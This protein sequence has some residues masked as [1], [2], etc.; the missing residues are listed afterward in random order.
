MRLDGLLGGNQTWSVNPKFTYPPT[1]V[2]TQ[3]SMDAWAAT[4]TS[5]GFGPLIPIADIVSSAVAVTGV[6]C[7]YINELGQSVV[8]SKAVLAA[9][10]FGTGAP[11]MPPQCSVVTTL[12]TNIPT[13]RGRGRLYWPALAAEI[14]SSTL[15]ISTGAAQGI[16]GSVGAWL[17]DVADA[18]GTATPIQPAVV[19]E[20]GAMATPI[21]SVR[22]GDVIDTQRRRRDQLLENYAVAPLT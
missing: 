12:Q 9:A 3:A 11:N 13:R 5:A 19:S 21:V 6:T 2:P 16:A 8:I 10:Q 17:Q 1:S 14:D 7:S 22:V 4:L 18:F 15:R 20:V